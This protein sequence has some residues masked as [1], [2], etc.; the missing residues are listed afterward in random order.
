MRTVVLLNW[1]HLMLRGTIS[2]LFGL[3]ALCFPQT[4]ITALVVLFGAYALLDGLIAIVFSVSAG[5]GHRAWA[6][7]IEGGLGI[8]VGIISLLWPPITGLILLYLIATWAVVT[9]VLEIAAMSWLKRMG[10]GGF[11][12][13]LSGVTSIVFGSALFFAPQPGV[14]QL[15][16]LLG[17]YG[18]VFGA[19]NIW[20]GLKLRRLLAPA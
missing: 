6:V 10:A 13:A 18:L 9:G 11:L 3:A 4:M 14:V 1:R 7:L 2:V 5:I 8:L 15:A 19:L 16:W 20:L 12:L 17:G